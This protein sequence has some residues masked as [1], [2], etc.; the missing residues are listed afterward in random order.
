MITLWQT[1]IAMANHHAFNGNITYFYGYVQ[2]RKLLVTTRGLSP[3]I[4][5]WFEAHG[6]N[7]DDILILRGRHCSCLQLCQR[8]LLGG[9]RAVA[10][11]VQQPLTRKHAAPG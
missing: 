5:F 9:P 7:H 8:L 11:F 2:V 1:N 10:I 4:P 6:S 3:C